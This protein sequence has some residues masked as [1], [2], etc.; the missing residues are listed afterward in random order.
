MGVVYHGGMITKEWLGLGLVLGLA[1]GLRIW[2]ISHD[3]WIDE[4]KVVTPAIS[5]VQSGGLPWLVAPNSYYPHFSHHILAL[6]FWPTWVLDPGLTSEQFH[7]IARWVGAAFNVATV[8]IVYAIGRRLLGVPGGILSALLLATMPL[9]VKYSHFI[10]VDLLAAF[11]MTAAVW[12]AMRLWEAAQPRWY[13]LTGVLIGAAGASQFWGLTSGIVLLLAH[14]RWIFQSPRDWRI[15]VRPAFIFS[16]LLIPLTFT[17]LSPHLVFQWEKYRESFTKIQLRGAAGDLGYTRPNILWP[18]Y[19]RSPDWSVAFT[20]AGLIWESNIWVFGF[21]IIGIAQAWWRK[22]WKVLILLGMGVTI[23]FLAI[24]GTLKL[25]AVKRL[26]PTGPLLAL[27]AA[28]GL[29]RLPRWA[30]GGLVAIA[31]GTG[32]WMVAGFD[33]AYARPATHGQAVAW[34]EKNIPIGS[35]VLQHSALRLLD[36]DDARWRTVRTE[37]VYANFSASDPEVAHDRAKPLRYWIE[38]H[39]VDFVVLDSRLVDRYYDLTSM[40]L[41]PEATASY[42]VFYDDVR[43]RGRLVYEIKPDPWRQA[44]ARIEI[45]DVRDVR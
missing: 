23:I 36:W 7:V 24:N 22:D 5:M 28:Y 35:G 43:S 44:G 45:F 3:A 12:S 25:Y 18:L 42:R 41:Y 9:H 10:Q 30:R 32:V 13:V 8:A 21:A 33:A 17:L 40:K 2:G 11:F 1:A 29:Q 37:Q 14:G 27:L 15:W 38:E 26:M 16:L 34:A 20:R 19:T 6:V 31:V 4:N 39:G